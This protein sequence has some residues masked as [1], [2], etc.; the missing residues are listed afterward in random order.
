MHKL[1][2]TT[3]VIIAIASISLVI[4]YY[5][6]VWS[7]YLFAP[8]YPEG[9]SMQI[10]LNRLSGDV[11]VIN[12]LN[13]Y[14]GM[15]HINAEMFPEFAIL[16]YIVAFFTILGLV[17]AFA[18]D[19]RVLFWYLV[20]TTFGGVFAMFDF[21]RWGYEYGHNLDPNAAI[22]VPGLSYQPP[23]LGHKRLL[24][25]DAYSYP[26]IGGWVVV[27]AAGILAIIW[28]STQFNS[29]KK[30]F[31]KPLSILLLITGLT[32]ISC[33]SEPEALIVGKDA[34][35]FCKMGIVDIK[36]GSEIITKKG[37]I[38][39]FDDIG[40]LIKWMKSGAVQVEH[41]NRILVMNYSNAGEWLDAQN[42][43]F[44][45]SESIHSPMNFNYAA[46]TTSEAAMSTL[47]SEKNEKFSWDMLLH[48]VEN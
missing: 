15:K 34:C 19:N 46:F 42:A 14:I 47:T 7:I 23:V 45:Q 24:N 3:R 26:D 18:G 4:C 41:L 48:R 43:V 28:I 6:P 30:Y 39:K 1:N 44:A 38:F 13:H 9:L 21:Y 33:N 27:I 35:S 2:F 10:W 29:T 36:Y 22:K 16:G 40:C 31:I 11:E 25:F 20:F 32:Q 5:V 12:G 37:K 8:Q 17:V